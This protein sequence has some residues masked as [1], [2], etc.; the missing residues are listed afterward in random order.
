MYL[1][2]IARGEKEACED[3]TIETAS[4][5]RACEQMTAGRKKRGQTYPLPLLLTLIMLAKLAEKLA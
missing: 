1:T 4:L 5:Y 2:I 3:L